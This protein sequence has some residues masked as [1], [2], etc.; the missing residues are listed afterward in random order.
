MNPLDTN[1]T[2]AASRFVVVAVLVFVAVSVAAIATVAG[3]HGSDRG[4]AAWV[5]NYLAQAGDALGR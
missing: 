5:G 4:I 1:T 3:D 2:R